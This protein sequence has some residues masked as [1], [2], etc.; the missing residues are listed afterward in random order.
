MRDR[1]PQRLIDIRAAITTWPPAG[2]W[3]RCAALYLI[4]LA[5]AFP[6]AWWAGLIAPSPTPMTPAAA[7]GLAALVFVHPA[8]FEELVFRALLLPR[9]PREVP[10]A[11]LVAIAA[12]ALAL[13]VAAHPLN[14]WLFSPGLRGLFTSPSYLALAALLGLTCTLAYFVS[15]SIWPPV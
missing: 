14:A 1:L 3:A 2:V 6:I 13:Y 4:F 11:R 10:R 9:R 7:A 15:S 8:F 5:C 12:I